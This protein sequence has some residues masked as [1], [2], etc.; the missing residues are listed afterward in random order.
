MDITLVIQA[1]RERVP[2]FGQRVAGAAEYKRLAESTTLTTPC[3]FVVPLDDQPSGPLTENTP[4]QTLDDAF[5]VILCLGQSDELGQSNL[6]TYHALRAAVWAALLGWRPT[7][8]YNG[9]YYQGGALLAHSRD[10]LWYQ[11]EFAASTAID[12]ADGWQQTE[13]AGLPHFD[14]VLAHIRMDPADPSI[15]ITALVPNDPLP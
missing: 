10:R 8:D 12:R 11:L 5:A 6:P 3:A 7:D 15:D 2:A 4:Y 9:V 13:L 14:G 1:L